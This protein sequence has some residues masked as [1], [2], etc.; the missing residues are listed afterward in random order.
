MGVPR[1]IYPGRYYF[2]SRR[3]SQRQFLLRPGKRTNWAFRYSL[4]EA[5]ARYGIE[6]V[7]FCASSN[8]HHAVVYDPHGCIPAFLAHFHKMLAKLLNSHLG[9][10]ENFWSSERCCYP[11]CVEP[12]DVF[13]ETVYTVT[14]PVKDQLV[15]RVFN[16]PGENSLAAQLS[17]RAL[18]VERPDWF[19]DA[20]GRM[21]ETVSLRFHRPHGFTELSHEAWADKL[22]AAVAEVEAKA[23]EERAATGTSVVGRKMVLSQ[24]PLGKPKSAEPRRNLRPQFACG[25]AEQR[26]EAIEQRKTFVARYRTALAKL[27]DGVRDV[28][29][30]AG[31]YLL[32]VRGLVCCEP[33]PA[34][35]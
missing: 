20:K 15:D 16:W 27:R 5:A 4:A 12:A 29:F 14:N 6:V 23:A 10:W 9:R 28:V 25:D 32:R 1:A 7:A 31:T 35:G 2:I 3:C 24:S 13:G 30:P 17:D 22:R 34:P 18:V 33:M 11:E 21:P 19:F 26:K 8:H